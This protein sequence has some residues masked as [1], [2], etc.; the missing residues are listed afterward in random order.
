MAIFKSKLSENYVTLPNVT[1]QDVELSWEARGLLAF[2]LSLPSDWAIYK[3]WLAEQSVMCGKDKLNRILDELIVSGYLVKQ[4]KRS[5]AGK[6]AE[7]DWLV[8]SEKQLADESNTA[9]GSTVTGKPVNGEPAATKETSIQSK[10]DTK[11]TLK[12]LSVSAKHDETVKNIFAIWCEKMNSPRSRLDANRK[13]LIV[14]ALKK[15]TENDLVAAITGCAM[16][17][18]HMGM[19]PDGK[20]YNGL[21]L[22][23]RNAEKIEQFIGFSTNPPAQRQQSA[24]YDFDDTSWVKDFGDTY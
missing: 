3:E 19:N 6:F 2:M 15:Y 14:N 12:E 10:Q 1:I 16:S 18:F 4:Q 24:G 21:D 11:E 22:I 5:G 17:P 9:D 7:N 23:L 20:K 8:Y 13:R